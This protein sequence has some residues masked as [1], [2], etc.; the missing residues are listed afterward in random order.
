MLSSRIKPDDRDNYDDDEGESIMP[1]DY[2][3]WTRAASRIAPSRPAPPPRSIVPPMSRPS[4]RPH[5]VPQT[6]APRTRPPVKPAT[7]PMR[8][9]RPRRR[10]LTPEIVIEQR[11]R[12]HSSSGRHRIITI[13]L[14]NRPTLG[15]RGPPKRVLEIERVRCRRRRKHRSS[16]YEIDYDIPPP[17]PPLQSNILVANPI[18]NPCLS[19][20]HSSLM[21]SANNSAASLALFSN[22]NPEMIENLPKKVVHLPPIYL[23]GSQANANTGLDTVVFPAEIINPING[24]LSI[25]Q[26]ASAANNLG[27]ANIQPP[28]LAPT[29][30]QL[31][32]APTNVESPLAMLATA[33]GPF[34][35]QVHDLLR[36]I[37]LSQSQPASSPFNHAINQ[38]SLPVMTQ[39]NAANNSFYNP[40]NIPPINTINRG[41]YPPAN[42]QPTII[43]NSGSY[44]PTTFTPSNSANITPYPPANITTYRP[45]GTTPYSAANITP[46]RPANITSYQP[47]G[48]GTTPYSPANIT[49]YHPANSTSYQPVGTGTMP[50]SP[51]NITPYH[52]ANSTSYQPVGTGTTPYTPANITP[53]HPA[54]STSYQ[55]V[56]TGTTPYSPANITPYHP[57]N[58][59]SYQPVGTGTTPYS[60]ANIT[61][62][63]PANIRPYQPTNFTP[64]NPTN[65][66]SYY[67][68]NNTPPNFADTGRYRPANITPYGAGPNRSGGSSLLPPSIPSTSMPYVPSSSLVSSDSFSSSSS[69]IG[70][71]PLNIPDSSQSQSQSQT[72][73]QSST[74]MPKSIL[75]NAPS[76]A[77]LN[78][79]Y[80][81]LNPPS[82]SFP[83]SIVRKT[84]TLV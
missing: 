65:T 22:L 45:A 63:H 78:T 73:Y 34:M 16:C 80:A 52:P 70:N 81:R 26:S 2:E 30:P 14:D 82:I 48:T 64:S 10:S 17:P 35:Q 18:L 40:Q 24:T 58:I 13:P 25:I 15:L 36:R 29:Q 9:R 59:T 51:A 23:P 4:R 19:P 61:P 11:H 32:S 12:H 57:A 67:P 62:Y 44:N 3:P 84:S 8:P 71:R 55:P 39:Y 33:S 41:P 50:Y 83:N 54:N 47:V 43:P 28:I 20:A 37:T 77:L 79:T 42:I 6:A 66:G 69:G 21:I 38:P 72:N 68:T 74:P 31:I 56:G 49:P 5:I 1:G 27:N 60:P 46:Y 76:N 75:R 7:S 53:Y